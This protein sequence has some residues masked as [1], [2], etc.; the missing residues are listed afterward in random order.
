M[1]FVDRIVDHPGRVRLTPVSGETNVYDI[2]R[3]EGEVYEPGTLL[4]ANNLNNP[5]ITSL[6]IGG[7]TVADW[8]IE[9]GTD[10]SWKYRKWKSGKIE[11]WTRWN[12]GTVAVTTASPAYGGYRSAGLTLAIPSGIFT[13]AP[14]AVGIKSYSQGGWL[15]NIMASSATSIGAFIGSAA[16]T[17]F[18]GQ[19][20]DIYAWQN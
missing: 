13:S 18:T 9:Q 14:F 8:V 2:T 17:T 12:V 20:I 6:K 3:E 5:D 19:T 15:A 4:N 11:A 1:A 7:E 16:S 10:G